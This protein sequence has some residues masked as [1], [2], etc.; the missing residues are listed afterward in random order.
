VV[1]AR[2]FNLNKALVVLEEP[3]AG[4]DVGAKRQIY[5]I[6]R[7]RADA[8]TAIAVVSTDF[9]EV[10]TVC[11]RV[12]VFRNGLIAAELKGDAITVENLLTLAAGGSARA[13]QT[14]PELETAA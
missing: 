13:A 12:L 3:T 5:E 11:T 7:E 9:E 10:A 8:G 2:W 6:L 14:A 4:V 1:L